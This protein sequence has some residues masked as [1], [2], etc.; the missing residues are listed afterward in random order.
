[1]VGKDWYT[2]YAAQWRHIRWDFY[3]YDVTPCIMGI[4]LNVLYCIVFIILLTWL[5]I[6][7]YSVLKSMFLVTQS[8]G[9]YQSV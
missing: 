9:T 8:V 7:K 1:M 3:I 6:T 5:F 4:F 2:D